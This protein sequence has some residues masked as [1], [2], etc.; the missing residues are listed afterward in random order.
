MQTKSER[1]V[2]CFG[3]DDW[4]VSDAGRV[5]NK[6]TQYV[7]KPIKNQNGY[8]YV[9]HNKIG[10]LYILSRLIA[11]SFFGDSDKQVNHKDG[12]K[13]NNCLNNLEFVTPSENSLHRFHVL[14]KSNLKPMF[15]DD[16]PMRKHGSPFI[17]SSHPRAKLTEED[18]K[19]IRMKIKEGCKTKEIQDSYNLSP[20]L[21]YRIKTNKIWTHV[22]M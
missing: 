1:W 7:Y 15:G 21:F 19:Q 17:G 16:N 10:K 5:R 14:G 3:I 20:Q 22:V 13:D 2:D 9:K 18:V 4:E 8:W 11:R 6:Q 12:N